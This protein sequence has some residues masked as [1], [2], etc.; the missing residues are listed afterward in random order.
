MAHGNISDKVALAMIALSIQCIFFTQGSYQD[1]GPIKGDAYSPDMDVLVKF[2]GGLLLVIALTLSAVKWNPAN[3]KMAGLGCFLCAANILHLTSQLAG[4]MTVL[5]R[6]HVVALALVAAGVHIFMYPSN[7]LLP[8]TH[9]KTKNNHG[10]ISDMVALLLI[11]VAVQSIFYTGTLFD[12]LGPLKANFLGNTPDTIAAAKFCGGLLLVIALML[13]SVKWN[14]ANGKMAGLGCFLCAANILHLTS[15][16]AGGVTTLRQ[17]HVVALALVV[18]GVHV[19]MYPSNPL[20]KVDK[21]K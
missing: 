9:P 6:F 19:F 21:Q 14:K 15:K 12:D 10:N 3:G 5:R 18:G 20:I 11:A 13:S 8:K 2:S 16:M 17:F 1:L 7:A 4:G